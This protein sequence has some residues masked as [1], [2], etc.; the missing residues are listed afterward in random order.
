[1]TLFKTLLA[2][3]I[4]AIFSAGA[5]AQTTATEVQRNVNQQERIEQGLQSGQ[6]NTKEAA[7]LEKQEA[8]IER[9]EKNAL[10]DG[11]LNAAEKARIEGAQDRVSKNI[12]REKHDVQTGNPQSASS[13]RMQ[14]NVQRNVNQQKR[15]EQGIKSGELKN[16]EVA[17]LEG[18]Q[19]HVNRREARAGA[20]GFVG[21]HEQKH[22]QTAENRASRKIY[23]EK[24]DA[25]TRQ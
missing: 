4:A 10:K 14:K 17:K 13:E 7:K 18:K 2:G 25:Q 19:A 20:D 22:I 1:M 24:H 16:R 9:M 21:K 11:K 5:Q 23:R 15:I 3:S 8:N 12:A 6:L